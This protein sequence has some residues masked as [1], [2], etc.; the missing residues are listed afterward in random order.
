MANLEVKQLITEPIPTPIQSKSTKTK[1][2]CTGFAYLIV[3]NLDRVISTYQKRQDENYYELIDSLIKKAGE[4]KKMNKNI[5]EDGEFI[6]Q[7]TIK[8][9]FPRIYSKLKFEEFGTVSDEY[10][11]IAINNIGALLFEI[12]VGK[13]LIVNRSKETFILIKLSQ[14]FFLVVDSHQPIHGKL[15]FEGA[16]KYITK[17]NNYQGVIQ[18]GSS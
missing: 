6:N 5:P 10:S 11:D 15:D 7:L 16:L 18:L 1:Y 17:Y 12:R 9:D 13:Y 2:P 14:E 8:N 3:E 4:R